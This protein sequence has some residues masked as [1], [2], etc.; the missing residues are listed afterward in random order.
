MED[1]NEKPTVWNTGIRYGLYLSLASVALTVIVAAAGGNPLQGD[2]KSWNTWANI[3]LSVALIVMA[4][5]HFKQNGSGFMTFG[6]GFGIAFVAFL[7]SMVVGGVFTYVYA[8][9]IDPSLMEDLWN[10]TEEKMAEQGQ[11]EE[12]IE[13]AIGFTKK[14]FWTLFILGGMFGAGVLSVII[15]LFTQKKNPDP[16]F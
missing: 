7:T 16:G 1:I 10:R 5:R 13:T 2:F 14:F 6:Q 3:G 9:V 4:H 15:T 8:N 12:V 11:S